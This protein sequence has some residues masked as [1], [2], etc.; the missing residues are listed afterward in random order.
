[1]YMT[2]KIYSDCQQHVYQARTQ[3]C[4]GVDRADF[5]ERYA[6]DANK[7]YKGMDPA[8]V[9]EDHNTSSCKAGDVALRSLK[10]A[11]NLSYEAKFHRMAS[12]GLTKRDTLYNLNVAANCCIDD[13]VEMCR[14]Q[15][16][17]YGNTSKLATTD[18]FLGCVRNCGYNHVRG[19]RG[20]TPF[21]LTLCSA[22]GMVCTNRSSSYYRTVMHVDGTMSPL[23]LGLVVKQNDVVQM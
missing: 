17:L 11:Y 3:R 14:R 6:Y 9:Y 5:I 4:T 22:R 15:R 7:T 12:K 19:N 21:C 1:M 13:D 18:W 2:G 16:T 20:T 23:N 10:V 8:K